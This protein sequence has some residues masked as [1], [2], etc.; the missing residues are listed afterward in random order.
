VKYLEPGPTPSGSICSDFRPCVVPVT[1]SAEGLPI[2]CRIVDG[3][4]KRT[5][6]QV[7][8]AIEA[9]VGGYQA[10]QLKPRDLVA[11]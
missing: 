5:G 8:A 1:R 4:G 11:P 9:R 10:P 2:A 7:A 6:L 3:L